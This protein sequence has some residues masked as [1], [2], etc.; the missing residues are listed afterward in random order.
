MGPVLDASILSDDNGD[1]WG[2]T[3]SFIALACQD[4]T[5]SSRAAEFDFLE[6]TQ[7]PTYRSMSSPR[8][9]PIE[10]IGYGLGDFASNVV[11]QSILILLPAF[12]TDVFGLAP[13]VMGMMF[14]VV[15]VL[16]TVI[17]PV[18][19]M[20]ADHTNTRWGKY[21]PWLLWGAV[22]FAL[23]FRAHLHS[24]QISAGRE[25]WFMP[26]SLMAY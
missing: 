26:T 16:D 7:N 15:R 24:R 3:G 9:S 4:L 14:L 20:I 18:M 8:L 22:P 1:H 25:N 23:L 10:K 21:R 11:F 6:I 13:A 2:F 17:D 12:Y 5:G 19:G